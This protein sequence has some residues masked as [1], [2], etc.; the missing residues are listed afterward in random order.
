MKGSMSI[1]V[2]ATLA[3]ACAGHGNSVG[4]RRIGHGLVVDSAI[5]GP[6]VSDKVGVAAIAQDGRRLFGYALLTQS[7]GDIGTYLGD[8]LPKTV[9]VTWRADVEVGRYW[10]TGRVIGDHVVEVDKRVPEDVI[11]YANAGPG[12]ALRLVFRVKDDGVLFGWDV[13]E[14]FGGLLVYTMRGGDV[15]CYDRPRASNATPNCTEGPL[16]SAPWYSPLGF[17]L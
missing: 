16:T 4:G 11:R 9:R 15:P 6:H 2:L 12:R 3:V 17:K 8:G 10:T 14:N 7:G 13:Q 1:S 5:A